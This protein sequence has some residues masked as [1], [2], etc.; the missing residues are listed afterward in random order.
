[1][2]TI[3]LIAVFIAVV[4][5]FVLLFFTVI[6]S[7]SVS[8]KKIDTGVSKSRAEIRDEKINKILKRF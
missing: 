6:E 4:N 1:M 3:G 5:I 8:K 7:I 2:W